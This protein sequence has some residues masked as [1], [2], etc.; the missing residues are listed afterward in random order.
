MQK[1]IINYKLQFRLGNAFLYMMLK[2]K[3]INEKTNKLHLSK[4]EKKK[5][6]MA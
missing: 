5:I 3:V 4:F 6:Q 1:K 2:A